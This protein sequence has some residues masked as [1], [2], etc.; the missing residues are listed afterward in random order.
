MCRFTFY[1]G[2]DIEIGDLVTRPANS[3]IHQST[4]ATERTEPL[5]GDGFGLAWYVRDKPV[6]ARFRSVTP[7]WSNANLAELAEVTRSHCILVHIRAATGGKFDVSEA[8]C[9]PFRCGRFTFMHNGDIPAFPRIR[10]PLMARLS[11]EGF[12]SIRGVTDT[13]HMFAIA[14]EELRDHEHDSSCELL[15]RALER[16]INEVLAL[17]E[18]YAPGTHAYLNFVVSDGQNAAACRFSSDPNYIDSLYINEGGRYRCEDGVCFMT[19]PEERQRALLISSEPLNQGPR[20][21][22]VPRN[23]V[24]LVADNLDIE[25]CSLDR[26]D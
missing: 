17:L 3:L 26:R 24:V 7:A 5:N 14:M 25:M 19:D 22:E 9:H 12:A 15:G 8:N 4:H 21:R 1:L 18:E 23:H 10:R 16:T 20:W 2:E 13:E 11:D 6:P